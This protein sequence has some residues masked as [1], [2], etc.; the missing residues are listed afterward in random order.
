MFLRM[1]TFK[2]FISESSKYTCPGQQ[3]WTAGRKVACAKMNEIK[4]R[5][6]DPMD[7]IARK[8]QI[9]DFEAIKNKIIASDKE[10]SGFKPPELRLPTKPILPVSK[11]RSSPKIVEEK[12]PFWGKGGG[13]DKISSRIA[14]LGRKRG[15]SPQ[16]QVSTMV[17]IKKLKD[18]QK[19]S[20]ASNSDDRPQRKEVEVQK[21]TGYGSKPRDT[22]G[23][24]GSLRNIPSPAGENSG[25]RVSGNY[26]HTNR[27]QRNTSKGRSGGYGRNY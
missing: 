19:K 24:S 10:Y 27:T 11:R 16:D 22:R 26:N 17:Q 20:K 4:N 23:S 13:N 1:R 9:K 5:K 14:S 18:A 12:K 2:E 8:E 25:M 7:H 3:Y 21:N 6:L 15:G